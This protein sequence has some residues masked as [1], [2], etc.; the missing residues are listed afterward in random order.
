MTDYSSQNPKLGKGRHAKT[1][2][3]TNFKKYVEDS[4]PLDFDIMLEIK[5]K[6]NSAQLVV[7]VLFKDERFI[8]HK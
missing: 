7:E 3:I 5:D 1:I 8:K 2:D 6:E 4:K